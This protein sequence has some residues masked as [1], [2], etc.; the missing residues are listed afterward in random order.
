MSALA[1]SGGA[2]SL[3]VTWCLRAWSLEDTLT[4]PAQT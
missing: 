2:R 3:W 1:V 4:E